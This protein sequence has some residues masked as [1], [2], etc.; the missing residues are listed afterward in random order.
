MGQSQPLERVMFWNG[1]ALGTSSFK[2]KEV[3]VR[4]YACEQDMIE[5]WTKW[6][7]DVDPDFVVGYNSNAYDIPYLMARARGN[8]L[9]IS[10]SVHSRNVWIPKT[11]Q[12]SVQAHGRIFLD[13]LQWIQRDSSLH[14]A[15]CDLKSVS[16]AE[17]QQEDC[18]KLSVDFEEMTKAFY[19]Q[20]SQS[21]SILLD[22]IEYCDR[23]SL[24]PLRLAMEKYMC[25]EK[26]AEMSALTS[27]P[28]HSLLTRGQQCKTFNQFVLCAHA[29]N[30]VFVKFTGMGTKRKSCVLVAADDSECEG[31]RE[32]QEEEEQDQEEEEDAKGKSLQGAAV[33]EVQ[34]GMYETAVAVLDFNSL[35]PS[36][37]LEHNLCM[38]TLMGIRRQ[39]KANQTVTKFTD[40]KRVTVDLGDGTSA[41]FYQEEESLTST[42]INRLLTARKAVR[43]QMKLTQD[44]LA[45]R[46]LDARQNAIKTTANSIYG[47]YGA[48]FGP[49]KCLAVAK[50]ITSI[51]RSN[52]FSLRD[53][54]IQKYNCKVIAGDTDSVFVLF[55]IEESADDVGGVK[56]VFELAAAAASFGS[57]LFGSKLTL[58]VDKVYYPLLLHRKKTYAGYLWSLQGTTVKRQDRLDMKGLKP[59]KRSECLLIKNAIREVLTLVLTGHKKEAFDY[60]ESISTRLCNYLIPKEEYVFTKSLSTLP[61]ANAT[62]QPSEQAAV[63]LKMQQR[64][65]TNVA[66]R[67]DRIAY[68]FVKHRK[69]AKTMD[70]VED[71]EWVSQHHREVKLDYIRY[72]EH[73]V[74]SLEFV[75]GR[76]DER[77]FGERTRYWKSEIERKVNGQQCISSFFVHVV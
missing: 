14:Y 70:K 40:P 72:Y 57:N 36:I 68:V 76:A 24:I 12:K 41:D 21:R 43:A 37:M 8:K 74:K 69:N 29:A 64:D 55:S 15:L 32:E 73:L 31:E 75:L 7:V 3:S 47:L 4:P 50:A 38:T 6:V 67:G 17:F 39:E 44:P 22:V 59:V 61:A 58:G 35:Y 49:M 45:L 66:Q 1:F 46:I 53:Q 65:P 19:C 52:L 10:R 9:E 2:H 20:D 26:L 51:A 56:K 25:V 48:A 5:A 18:Q 16:S 28:I 30:Y 54:L 62:R 42:I 77:R 11:Q 27:T 60:L 63:A 33:L 34:P 13:V 23:D 71:P